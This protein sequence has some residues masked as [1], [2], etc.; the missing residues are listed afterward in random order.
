M[1]NGSVFLKSGNNFPK[2]GLCVLETVGTLCLKKKAK[3][4]ILDIFF[5]IIIF[6]WRVE[7]FF[8]NKCSERSKPFS[9]LFRKVEAISKKW[10]KDFKNSGHC[11][12]KKE[13]RSRYWIPFLKY[14][15]SDKCEYFPE[16]WKYCD[17]I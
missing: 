8:W 17:K 9:V 3:F 6:F 7:A 2:S 12:E 15:F 1:E 14:F 11:P 5:K 13:P 10:T 4:Y 16:K